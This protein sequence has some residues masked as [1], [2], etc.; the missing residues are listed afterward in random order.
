M[1]KAEPRSHTSTSAGLNSRPAPNSLPLAKLQVSER[2]ICRPGTGVDEGVDDA[3]P[4]RRYRSQ[5]SPAAPRATTSCTSK[6]VKDGDFP[7]VNGQPIGAQ[8]KKLTDND[9]LQLAGVKMGF[10][11]PS[12][13]GP[14][15]A[16][17]APTT[18]DPPLSQIDTQVAR[19]AGS[20]SGSIRPS[21]NLGILRCRSGSIRPSHH[22]G[23]L[24]CTEPVPRA[25][26]RCR[27][28]IRRSPAMAG[29][30]VAMRVVRPVTPH[31]NW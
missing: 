31:S 6:A 25:T 23:I 22:L 16:A 29:S 21:H 19:D 5:P 8:A 20:Y 3:G 24:R 30:Y 4:P 28:S 11:R 15:C 13:G 27:N 2:R 10:L 1:P 18:G 26:H 9:V 12:P 7:L 14:Y 17:G